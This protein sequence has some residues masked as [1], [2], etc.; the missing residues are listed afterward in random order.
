ME[1]VIGFVEEAVKQL[2]NEPDEVK[3]TEVADR[4][5]KIIKVMVSPNDV[6]RIIGKDGRVITNLRTMANAVAGK[7][8][9]KAVV[10]V[11]TED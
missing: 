11:Q 5:G 7:A 1:T 10:K 8:R 4:H 9:V 2:V 6:G 3:V